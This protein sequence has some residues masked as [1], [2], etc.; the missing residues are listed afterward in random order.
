M[1]KGSCQEGG[2]YAALSAVNPC[3]LEQRGETPSLIPS[4]PNQEGLAKSSALT[5]EPRP[6][7]EGYKQDRS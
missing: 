4:L 5:H 1:S 2:E 6:N 7:H 3:S